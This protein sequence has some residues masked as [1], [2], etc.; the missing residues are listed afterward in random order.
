MDYLWTPWRYQYLTTADKQE[1][2]VFCAAAESS[3]DRG[4]LVVHRAQHNFVILNRYPY[5]SG[6]VMVV[7]YKHAATLEDLDD[8]T[9]T[10]LMRLARDTE[11]HFRAL[12]RPEG[13]NLGLNLGK[14]AGAGIAG[15]LH[16]HA[17]PRWVADANFMTVVGETR[18]LPETLDVTWQRLSGAFRAP[19]E[20]AAP[21]PA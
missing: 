16:L 21:P 8:A 6:H 20:A 5:T 18:I 7:P 17:L 11:R 14:A 9:L 12:Y 2:C 3:D 15:H 13:V 4:H 1:G 19:S 10:E